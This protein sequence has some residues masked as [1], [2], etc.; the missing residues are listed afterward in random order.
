MLVQP[1]LALED[2]EGNLTQ[3]EEPVR[4][5][6]SAEWPRYSDETFPRELAEAQDALDAQEA[7]RGAERTLDLPA[8]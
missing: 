8:P 2:D 3:V 5:I 6:T 4:K 7:I 1:I